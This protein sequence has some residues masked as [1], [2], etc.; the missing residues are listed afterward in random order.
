MAPA[1]TR[2]RVYAGRP[3]NTDGAFTDCH[4]ASTAR[5]NRCKLGLTHT[6]RLRFRSVD[7]RPERWVQCVVSL[8]L[9]GDHM[10]NVLDVSLLCLYVCKC[11]CMSLAIAIAMCLALQSNIHVALVFVIVVKI[12]SVTAKVL[13][14]VW[15]S[16]SCQHCLAARYV[17]ECVVCSASPSALCECLCVRVV[18]ALALLAAGVWLWFCVLCF[19]VVKVRLLIADPYAY[20]HIHTCAKCRAF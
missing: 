7:T 8:T 17:P 1:Q 18:L 14:L 6:C 11:T 5:R 9:N 13:V 19:V 4:C 16:W 20:C 10:H 2:E 12:C 15:S 3:V